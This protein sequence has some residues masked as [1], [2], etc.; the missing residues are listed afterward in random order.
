MIIYR[1]YTFSVPDKRLYTFYKGIIVTP[2]PDTGLQRVFVWSCHL[3]TRHLLSL[4]RT[5]PLYT[6]GAA[7]CYGVPSTKPRPPFA[8]R[9]RHRN[10]PRLRP[11]RIGLLRHPA[12]TR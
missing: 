4:L 9:L 8:P 6:S 3:Y 11:A 5:T 2:C 1:N 7:T 10:S 12:W